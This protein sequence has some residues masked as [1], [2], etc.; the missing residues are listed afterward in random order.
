MRTLYV[1][2]HADEAFVFVR[3]FFAG[4]DGIIQQ[5]P[6]DDAQIDFG[7][8]KVFGYVHFR[9]DVYLF[10][11]G[12]GQLRIQDRIDR[13]VSGIYQKIHIRKVGVQFL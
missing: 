8:G 3:D 10:Y 11:G 5:I 1:H 2:V 6:D 13:H 4:F 9:V 12:Q 7:Y